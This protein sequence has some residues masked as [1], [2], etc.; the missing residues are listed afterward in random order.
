MMRGCAAGARRELNLVRRGALLHPV[1]VSESVEKV[2][3]SKDEIQAILAEL[4]TIRHKINND[5]TVIVA[6]IDLIEL[7]PEMKEQLLKT[8][9]AR[10]LEITKALKT[11]SA[12]LQT[13]LDPA[14]DEAGGRKNDLFARGAG[15]GPAGPAAFKGPGGSVAPQQPG[16]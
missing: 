11:F 13:K 8:I 9:R 2:Q 12:Y 6:S 3:L 10:P 4:K 14:G 15:A 5:V 7:R 1:W 16:S